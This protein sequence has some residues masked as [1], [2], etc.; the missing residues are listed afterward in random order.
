MGS[1]GHDD[2]R[3]MLQ[4]TEISRRDLVKRG[5]VLGV[6]MPVM[7]SLIAACDVDDDEL[8][9]DPG[10]VEPAPDDDADDVPDDDAEPAED[11][12]DV[13]D[14]DDADE[15]DDDDAEDPDDDDRYGGRMILMAH[16]VVD[17]LHPDDAGPY[18]EY[19]TIN[20]IC[21]P[22]LAVTET[23]EIEPTL[24][25]DYDVSDDGLTYTLQLREDV[26]FHDGEPFTAGDVK[27]TYDWYMD[28]DNASLM[29]ADFRSVDSVEVDGDY[30]V[31]V[32]MAEPD[33]SLLRLGLH[34]FIFPEHYHE[35]VGYEGFSAEPIGTGPF[36]V[37]DWTPDEHTIMEAFEDHWA[38]RPYLDELE[39][40]VIPEPS[41]RALELETGGADSPI[42]PLG[43]D[44]ALR[45][46]DMTDEIQTIQTTSFPVNHF[47]INN[48]IPQFDDPRVRQALMYAINREVVAENVYAGAAA[49]AHSCF[50]PALE[51]Y[52]AD[53]LYQYE[54]DP[55]RARELLDEAGWVE[56]GDGIRER[57]GELWEWTC[58]VGQG[59]EARR[60][61]AEMVSEF[62]SEIG[63][64]MNITE[65]PSTGAHMREGGDMALFNWNYGGWEGEPDA[66]IGL[67]TGGGDNYSHYSNEEMDEL[68]AEGVRLTEVEDRQEVYRRV[69]ELFVEEVPFLYQTYWDWFNQFSIRVQGLPDEADVVHGTKLYRSGL[70]RQYWLSE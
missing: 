31:I 28:T 32:N 66:R 69:Q 68:L 62:V 33:I 27:Y 36:R 29:Y 67:S 59:D 20:N 9:D 22:L 13:D 18:V 45:L 11:D 39:V 55:D 63:G 40:R 34:R 6:S 8:D 41:V 37:I 7:G 23:H 44:D 30:T 58:A 35:E 10:G 51:E 19:S 43:F 25:T 1:M 47:P 50:P 70:V 61:H 65:V 60:P 54:F 52:Y 38:G 64:Q 46:Q 48:E 3:S 14:A 16:G 15:P 49:V 21:E 53:D 12:P 26:V 24:A 57:D 5:A 56:N 42:W 4:G 17:S 2:R